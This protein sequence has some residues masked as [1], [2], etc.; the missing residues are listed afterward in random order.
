MANTTTSAAQS[1]PEPAVDWAD[2][3]DADQTWD[4]DAQ[5]YPY[6]LTPLSMD[7]ND[8]YL[9]SVNQLRGLAPHELRRV[10]YWHGYVYTSW[11]TP[12]DP[13]SP[14]DPVL[15]ARKRDNEERAP[16][17]REIWRTEILPKVRDLCLRLQAGAYESMSAEDLTSR[18]GGLIDQAGHAFGLTQTAIGPALACAE[19]IVAF[20]KEEVGPEGE[21]MAAVLMEGFANESSLSDIGLW[22]L[23]RLAS[24]LPEVDRAIRCWDLDNLLKALPEVEGGAIL[25]AAFRRYLDRYGWRPEIWFELSLPALREDPRPALRSVRRYLMQAEDSPR[26]AQARSA[27]RR[28]RLTAR[29]RRRLRGDP[30]K[31]ARFETLLKNSRQYVPVREGRALWQLSAGGGACVCPAWRLAGSCLRRAL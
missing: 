9:R 21:G 12:P 16:R 22:D 24:T 28:R 30:D 20:C 2:A 18:L 27:G 1:A 31:L 10:T 13:A 26:K 3:A 7:F 6:P 14:P 19:S 25:L 8:S 17:I 23:A 29:L 4:W 11:R 5:H 15:E